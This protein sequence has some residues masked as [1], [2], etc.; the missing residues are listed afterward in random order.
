MNVYRVDI[1]QVVKDSIFVE[2]DDE[3]GALEDAL[4]LW[5]PTEANDWDEPE[6]E[7]YRLP[8]R[9]KD[10]RIWTGGPT[11]HWSESRPH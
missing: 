8:G 3:E 7:V 11:G 5:D 6:V 2:A 10:V 1:E 9:P 4:G